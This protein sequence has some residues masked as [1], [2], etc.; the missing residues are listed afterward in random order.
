[1]VSRGAEWSGS[2]VPDSGAGCLVQFSLQLP[3]RRSVSEWSANLAIVSRIA[4]TQSGAISLN[5]RF[6]IQSM[7]H[8]FKVRRLH[9]DFLT[10][11][12]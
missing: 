4:V 11:W 7:R 3:E 1:M 8:G 2:L 6:Y 5:F 10:F 9:N 12:G